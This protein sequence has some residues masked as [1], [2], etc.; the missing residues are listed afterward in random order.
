MDKVADPNASPPTKI[1]FG[2]LS[3]VPGS[4]PNPDPNA[5]YIQESTFQAVYNLPKYDMN[6]EWA[7][8]DL[9]LLHLATEIQ[10]TDQVRPICLATRQP[11]SIIYGTRTNN[12]PPMCYTAGWGDQ[13][14]NA[15]SKYIGGYFQYFSNYSL[16][17]WISYGVLLLLFTESDKQRPFLE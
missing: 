12:G 10:I 13:M 17:S 14:E 15:G 9:T 4:D 16:I 7:E 3:V 6:D 11:E 1:V 2:D 5:Q 8:G